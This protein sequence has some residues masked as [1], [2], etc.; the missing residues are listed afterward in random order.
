VPL[1]PFRSCGNTR[2]LAVK[3]RCECA[4]QW[5]V[6][7][8]SHGGANSTAPEPPIAGGAAV[9]ALDFNPHHYGISALEIHFAVG[10]ASHADNVEVVAARSDFEHRILVIHLASDCGKH[11]TFWRD[12]STRILV[13]IQTFVVTQVGHA[14]V[15]NSR[16]AVGWAFHVVAELFEQERVH[17]R[18]GLLAVD[19]AA[20]HY[21]GYFL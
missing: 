13:L 5:L 19:G 21:K 14:N 2:L 10:P 3:P 8:R 1:S 15:L 18:K 7:W 20:L 4:P 6:G 9:R 12:R 11:A 16:K 17:F